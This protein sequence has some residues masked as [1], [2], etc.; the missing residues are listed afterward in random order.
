MTMF[1]RFVTENE[2]GASTETLVSTR[3]HNLEHRLSCTNSCVE[4]VRF[5][6]CLPLA[7]TVCITCRII[8]PAYI[9]FHISDF[10]FI[11]I[12]IIVMKDMC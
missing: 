12:S 5:N 10:N 6:T 2:D 8:C 1:F 3:R 11:M 4:S 7:H 9:L